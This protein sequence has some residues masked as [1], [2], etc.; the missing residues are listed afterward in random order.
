MYRKQARKQ[1]R[2]DPRE[3]PSHPHVHVE[4]FKT[5]AE[6]STGVPLGNFFAEVHNRC[7]EILREPSACVQCGS[8]RNVLALICEACATRPAAPVDEE[9]ERERKRL[10]GKRVRL[11]SGRI[12]TITSVEACTLNGCKCGETWAVFDGSAITA[13]SAEPLPDD[14]PEVTTPLRFEDLRIGEFF[15]WDDGSKCTVEKLS[16]TEH[17]YV[18]QRSIHAD[19]LYARRNDP[20]VRRV[21]A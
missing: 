10:V 18:G 8:E 2:Y 17:R 3:D 6:A 16:P 11:N 5:Y 4:R 15:C 21:R 14:K 9:L 19:S 20:N 1:W 12:V 13:S 7:A